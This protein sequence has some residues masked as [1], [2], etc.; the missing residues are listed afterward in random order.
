ML[1]RGEGIKQRERERIQ[2]RDPPN[3]KAAAKDRPPEDAPP[4]ARPCPSSIKSVACEASAGAGSATG[5]DSAE[6]PAVAGIGRMRW[7]SRLANRRRWVNRGKDLVILDKPLRA[8]LLP[9]PSPPPPA[10]LASHSVCYFFL[11]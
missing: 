7:N 10:S 4:R 8:S 6:E 1:E 2:E 11:V 9:P 5:F 3:L